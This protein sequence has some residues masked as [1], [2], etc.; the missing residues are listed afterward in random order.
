MVSSAAAPAPRQYHTRVGPTPPPPPHLRPSQRAPSSKRAQTSSPGESLSS[1]PHEPQSAPHQGPIGAPPLDLSPASIIRRPLFHCNPIPGNAKYSE[2]D[3]HDE[4]YYYF[5]SFSTD[6]ELRD[7]MLLVQRYSL[8]TFMTPRRFFYPQVV[9]EFYHTMTSRRE[10][11]STAL[12]F[13]IDGRPGILR[14]SDIAATFNFQVVLANLAEYR[15]WPHPYPRDMVRLLSKDITVR[16]VM[17][18]RQLPSHMLLINHIMR[19]N[20]FRFSIPFKG[21]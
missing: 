16:S 19:S 6:P 4:V 15:Q 3:L 7:S 13:S 5:P 17:F 10:P 11:H 9:I 8:E 18:R 2:R 1:R 21:E 12:H 20:L 14:A